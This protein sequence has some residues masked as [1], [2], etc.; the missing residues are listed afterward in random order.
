MMSGLR[1]ERQ[2]NDRRWRHRKWSQ[3]HIGIPNGQRASIIYS[4][5]NDLKYPILEHSGRTIRF[6]VY[7]F[8]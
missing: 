6:S 7:M 2:T 5:D 3:R 8:V 4:Q 1:I